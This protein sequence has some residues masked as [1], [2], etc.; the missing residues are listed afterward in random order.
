MNFDGSSSQNAEKSEIGLFDMNISSCVVVRCRSFT[1]AGMHAMPGSAGIRTVFSVG[2]ERIVRIATPR[3]QFV[4]SIRLATEQVDQWPL[5][6][7]LSSSLADFDHVC[8]SFLCGFGIQRTVSANRKNH[9]SHRDTGAIG[10]RSL[11]KEI[12]TSQTKEAPTCRST[13]RPLFFSATHLI[14]TTYH[15]PTTVAS[16][17][18][19]TPRKMTMLILSFTNRAEPSPNV[20]CAPPTWVLLQFVQRPS[21]LRFSA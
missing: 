13:P 9:A 21:S 17:R 15:S 6:Q 7:D 19:T 8:P 11:I 20:H 18:V 2:F 3:C 1:P 16:A 10:A 12:S 5:R 14:Q 4:S